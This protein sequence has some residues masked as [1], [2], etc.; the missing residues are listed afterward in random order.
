[1]KKI[2]GNNAN[3]ICDIFVKPIKNKVRMNQQ[4]KGQ[5]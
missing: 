2:G 3:M 4:L 1:M 5:I